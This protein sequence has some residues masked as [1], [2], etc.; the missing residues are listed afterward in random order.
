VFL[1][2][3]MVYRNKESVPGIDYVRSVFGFDKLGPNTEQICDHSVP[4][5]H[6]TDAIDVLNNGNDN[7]KGVDD[8]N[9]DDA[10]IKYPYTFIVFGDTSEPAGI[11]KDMIIDKIVDE[12]PLFVIHTGDM[13]KNGDAHQWKIFDLSEGQILDNDIDLYPVLGNHD[14]CTTYDEEPLSYYFDRFDFLEERR[15]YYFTYGN[16]MFIMLDSNLDYS[17]GSEQY[18]WLVDVLAK[19]SYES[20]D[21]LNPDASPL[22]KHVF[23]SLHHPVYSKG[24]HDVREYEKDLGVLLESYTENNQIKPNIVFSGHNHNYERYVSNDINYIVTGGGGGQQYK[25]DRDVDDLY[26]KPGDI[27]HYSKVTVF[28]DKVEFEMVKI[29]KDGDLEENENSDDWN[30]VVDDNFV[31][32]GGVV[33][34]IRLL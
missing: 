13:V 12:A 17:E 22:P 16:S 14:Y 20:D 11:E 33:Y 10:D 27:Y 19:E 9:R 29:N 6:K 28:E 31:I 1:L 2:G 15:W 7:D 8:S 25:V 32:S 21:S 5:N 30:W 4:E 23:L 18:N 24:W 3:A 26:N 34:F